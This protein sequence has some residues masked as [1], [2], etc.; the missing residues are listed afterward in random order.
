MS[1]VSNWLIPIVKGILIIGFFGGIFFYVGKACLNGWK[2][3]YKFV[4]KY[5]ILR[6]PYSESIVKWC[7]ESIDENRSYYDIKKFLLVKMIPQHEINEILWIYEKLSKEL[8]GG[9]MENGRKFKGIGNEIEGK[10]DIPNYSTTDI[11]K[12]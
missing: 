11:P 9:I 1:F 8:K 4:F 3:R 7:M 2:K 5:K 10:Q 6:R 12:D